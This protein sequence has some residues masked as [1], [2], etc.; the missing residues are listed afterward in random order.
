[1][2]GDLKTGLTVFWGDDGLDTGPI[3][4]QKEVEVDVNDTVN[5]LYKRYLFPQVRSLEIS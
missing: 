5:G 2:Q 1:M 3:L 4:L